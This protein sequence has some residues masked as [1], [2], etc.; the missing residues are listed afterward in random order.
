MVETIAVVVIIGAAAGYTGRVLYRMIA[1]R[2]KSCICDDGCP[3]ATDCSSA[4]DKCAAAS[5][6]LD[7]IARRSARMS[8]E[9]KAAK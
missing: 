3:M 1:G 7:D 9:R 8:K 6:A 4:E 5:Q 2:R